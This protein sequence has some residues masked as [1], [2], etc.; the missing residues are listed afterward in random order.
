MNKRILG[1]ILFSGLLGLAAV[2]SVAGKPQSTRIPEG[3]GL[4]AKYPGE[5]GIE[6]DPAV[7]FHEDFERDDTRKWDEKK[8][9]VAL[10]T[11]APHSGAKCVAMPMHRGKDN[12]GHL[13]K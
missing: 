1:R 8:G 10:T 7:L 9:P 12:G 11:E 3:Q 6:K 13:I 2:S 5:Q 4:A